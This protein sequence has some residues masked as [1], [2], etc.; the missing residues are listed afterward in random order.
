MN[1]ARNPIDDY[2][3]EALDDYQITP[4]VKAKK[5]FMGEVLK[6]TRPLSPVWRWMI[7]VLLVSVAALVVT[8]IT[9]FPTPLQT[10]SP[11]QTTSANPKNSANQT[12]SVSP[13]KR[14]ISS[15][16][17]APKRSGTPPQPELLSGTL[18][19]ESPNTVPMQSPESPKTT[20]VPTRDAPKLVPA[21]DTVTVPQP[22]AATDKVTPPQSDTLATNPSK[23]TYPLQ[24]TT[25]MRSAIPYK[26]WRISAG[27][28]FS[29]EWMFHTLEGTKQA[30]NFG[31]E[32][33]FR[34]GRY[35]I[36]TG[37]GLSI[38]K[39]T[40]QLA[41]EYNDYLGNYLKL[42]SITF[43]WD[44][45]HSNLIP[46]Y[47][48]SNKNV[49]DSLM[50]LENAKII[51]RYTYLQVPLILGYDIIAREKFSLGFRVGPVMSVL[52]SSRQISAAY[53]PGKKQIISINMITPEQIALNWQIMAGINATFRFSRRFGL[54]LEPFGKYYLNSVYENSGDSP[55]PWSL[56]VRAAFFISF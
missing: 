20:L 2:F 45:S 25:C 9:I 15:A 13:P 29:P 38:T 24:L 10:T 55:K 47:F 17:P 33:S 1:K 46:T 30:T 12:T 7:P 56:G 23:P 39:G 40:N 49:Y 5:A 18:T 50:K 36:R 19:M 4:S 41:I 8:V 14:E 54:E 31:V 37:A 28:Y 21:S 43:R 53:D 11:Q 42:D 16:F 26:E 48:L 27:L 32:G 3:R 35:S 34:I 6:M 44:A 52:L 51:K 22:V